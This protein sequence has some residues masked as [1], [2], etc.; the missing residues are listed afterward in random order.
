VELYRCVQIAIGKQKVGGRWFH[1][2]VFGD[3]PIIMN[4]HRTR[5]TVF[6]Q[7]SHGATPGLRTHDGTWSACIRMDGHE[8]ALILREDADAWLEVLSA[9][10]E[11]W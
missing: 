5:A 8:A 11:L 4:E 7:D 10:D 3:L 9:H 2:A 1:N 6:L